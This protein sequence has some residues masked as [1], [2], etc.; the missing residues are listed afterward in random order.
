[1]TLMARAAATV[2]EVSRIE[3]TKLL[4]RQLLNF[5]SHSHVRKSVV[6]GL[7]THPER[8]T[9]GTGGAALRASRF[10]EPV[11]PALRIELLTVGPSNLR[12]HAIEYFY[13]IITSRG[14]SAV[15]RLLMN[16]DSPKPT[17]ED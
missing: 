7:F 6:P 8:R 11:R 2:L 13:Q 12:L 10:G 1:M 5:H 3:P 16:A 17:H 9:V 4:S 15:C 14:P